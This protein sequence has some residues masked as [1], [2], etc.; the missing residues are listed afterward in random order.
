MAKVYSPNKKYDGITAGVQFS[1]GVGETKD[2]YILSYLKEK[3]YIVEDVKQKADGELESLKEEAKA[4]GISFNPNIGKAKLV[5]KIEE[6]KKLQIPNNQDTGTDNSE[7][8][9][10]GIDVFEDEE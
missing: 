5:E 8:N 10:D 3:G 4:L 2:K 1:N 7:E 6:A 9:E